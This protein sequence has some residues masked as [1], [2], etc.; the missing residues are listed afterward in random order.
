M[1]GDGLWL[2][3]PRPPLHFRTARA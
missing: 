3:P 2:A 1:V